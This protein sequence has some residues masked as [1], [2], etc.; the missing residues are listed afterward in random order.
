MQALKL[1]FMIFFTNY[2]KLMKQRTKNLQ[3][4]RKYSCLKLNSEDMLAVI[5]HFGYGLTNIIK[6]QMHAFFMK[7]IK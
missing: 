3:K 2:T 6:R 4:L 5:N 1:I 7:A